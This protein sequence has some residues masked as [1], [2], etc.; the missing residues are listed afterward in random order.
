MIRDPLEEVLGASLRAVDDATVDDVD[1]GDL[2]D[3]RL[4]RR[5]FEVALPPPFVP[6]PPEP[7]ALPL[8]PAGPGDGAALAAVQ[9]RAWRRGYRGLL[10]DR[11]LDDLDF[12]Y[13]GAYW[14]GRATV[15]PTPRHRLLVA[16]PRGEVHGMVDVGP[17]RDDDAPLGPDGL[18]APGEVRSLYVDPSVQGR[19]LG[20][21]LLAAAEAELA[22][23]GSVE[24]VLWVVE[25]NAAARRFYERRGWVAD[26]IRKVTPV[27]DEELVE[28]RYRWSQ[29]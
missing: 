28:V 2:R 22:G 11:F 27:A 18:P 20:A 10:S 12:S 16:G 25:G 24:L 13:L 6:V 29:G 8:R 17:A 3:L 4:A 1:R 5:R 15:S 14:T 23:Q 19:G 21:A 26:G 7:A 9:R